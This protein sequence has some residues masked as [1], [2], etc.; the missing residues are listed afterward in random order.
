MTLRSSNRVL[1]QA[2]VVLLIFWIVALILLTRPLPGGTLPQ[3][4]IVGED[5]LQRLSRAVAE[6]ENLKER[7]QELQWVLAN[8]SR[9]A[10][11]SGGLS[12]MKGEMVEKLRSTLEGSAHLG[13]QK[14]PQG[15][16]KEYEIK[17]RGAYRGVQ[18]MWYYIS[19]ELEK[20][21]KKAPG[22]TASELEA[23]IQEI[24]TSGTE[25][26]S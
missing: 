1:A 5:V 15:P 4:D 12:H 19:H 22:Q 3:S 17:R 23:L 24:I 18:E 2:A 14:K 7:N 6:L 9:E 11:S 21:K 10:G 25:H 20:L 13:G 16:S 8:F 26:E